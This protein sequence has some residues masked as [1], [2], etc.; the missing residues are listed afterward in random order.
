[1]YHCVLEVAALIPI[2][3][4]T[5]LEFLAV[6]VVMVIHPLDTDAVAM[7]NQFSD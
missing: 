3:V 5:L 2:R 4:L 6:S 1:M 7:Q